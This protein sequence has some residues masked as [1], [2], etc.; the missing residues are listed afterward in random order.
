LD[1]LIRKALA[2]ARADYA[3]IR[4]CGGK[5]THVAYVGRELES[6]REQTSLGGCVRALLK[7][8]WGFCSFNEVE[9]LPRYVDIACSQARLVGGGPHRLAPVSP[10]VDRRASAP[11]QSPARV[12]LEEK[13]SLCRAYND[14]ILAGSPKIQSSHVTYSDS[15]GFTVFAS[16]EGALVRQEAEFCGI[17]LMAVARNG[18]DVQTA[19]FSVGDLR[20][21]QV[22]R[23]LEH[24][25]DEV[26]RRS[27]DM[28]SAPKVRAGRYDV[29]LDPLLCGVF[30]H[31]AFGHLSEADFLHQNPRLRD[32]MRLGRRFGADHLN[33]IDD[34][35]LPGEAGS[36]AFDAEGVPAHRTWLI[37]QG[38][39]ASRLHSRETAAAMDEPPTGNARAL[40]Y[41]F[42]PIVRMSNT[43]LAPGD[44]TF[45]SMVAGI[46]RGIYARGLLGGQT[47][48]EM[49]SFSAE[50]AFMIRK[51][52]V[53]ERV[54]DV[55]L[56]GNVFE[57]LENIDAVGSDLLLYGGLGGCG[58][59]NQSPL[60]VSDGGPHVRIRDVLV[61]G[62]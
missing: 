17:L 25:C 56:T 40:G 51:G 8:G 26:V 41:G 53:A 58:K 4:V 39:L 19:H 7:G 3:E 16:T 18:G 10:V 62:A 21:F 33:I 32:I 9:H 13:E 60:R 2:G 50:E 49:F 35:T 15:Q 14:R 55:V 11:L 37:R 47:D 12:S 31:E 36:Y 45:E 23:G 34:A 52:R 22:C 44:A 24:R 29:I 54:R 30:V 43:F 57:T 59:G 20:G 38:R 28:L 46:D 6:L 61:G 42:E 48:M 5:T 27:V 1:D